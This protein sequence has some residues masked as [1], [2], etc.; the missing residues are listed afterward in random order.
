MT[1]PSPTASPVRANL[2]EVAR[3]LREAHHL[4]A[5]AQRELADLVDELAGVLDP[6]APSDQAAHL[7]ETSAHLARALH[8]P[9]HPGLLAAAKARLEDAAARAEVN[10]PVAT[11]VARRLIDALARLGI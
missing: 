3:L 6:A 1:D 11:G 4:D 7:A 9:H 8:D 10:A 5:A 2:L